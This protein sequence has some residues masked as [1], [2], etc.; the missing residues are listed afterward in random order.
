MKLNEVTKVSELFEIL[1]WEFDGSGLVVTD[2]DLLRAT[3]AETFPELINDNPPSAQPSDCEICGEPYCW[4]LC[5]NC[6]LREYPE[7]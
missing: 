7:V 1:D 2:G 3:I 6:E 5:R 4:P